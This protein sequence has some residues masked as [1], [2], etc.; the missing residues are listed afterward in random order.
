MT[1][2]HVGRVALPTGF[3]WTRT[4]KGLSIEGRINRD[5][6]SPITIEQLI[7]LAENIDEPH[8]PVWW[9]HDPIVDGFYRVANS[10]WRAT[11]GTGPWANSF[12]FSADLE[13]VPGNPGIESVL[14]GAVRANDHSITDTNV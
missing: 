6:A 3:S 14:V 9:D 10:S 2:L 7:G 11:R 12:E 8:V 1:D 5:P 4:P 13:R